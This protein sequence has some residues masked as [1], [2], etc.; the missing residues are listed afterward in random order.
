MSCA[1]GIASQKGRQG[2]DVLLRDREIVQSELGRCE[3][4][5]KAARAF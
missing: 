3:A 2:S 4:R 5:I 1:A